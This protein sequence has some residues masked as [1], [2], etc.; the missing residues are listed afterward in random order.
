MD[1]IP[2]KLLSPVGDFHYFEDNQ[3]LTAAQLNRFLDYFD[4]QHRLT[5]A[6]GL[7]SGILC[8]LNV[9]L[10]TGG[11][12]IVSAGAGITTDGDIIHVDADKTLAHFRSFDD[13]KAQYAPFKSGATT[14]PLF[15]L[16]TDPADGSS[17]LADFGTVTSLILNDMCLVLYLNSYLH[18]PENCT[19]TSCEITGTTQVAEL[20]F[21]LVRKNDLSALHGSQADPTA[22]LADVAIERVDLFQA[23]V[24]G[25]NNLMSRF[26]ASINRSGPALQNA[27]VAAADT[28]RQKI[29]IQ[30]GVATLWRNRL[31]AIFN[32]NE[33]TP[34]LPYIHD[35]ARDL[36]DAYTEYRDALFDLRIECPGDPTLYPKHLM[37][38]ELASSNPALPAE[39]RHYFVET[40]A[41][42]RNSQA[43]E[44]A[45]MLFERLDRMVNTFD[46]PTQ[47]NLPVRV[48][49][50]RVEN[51]PLGER[52]IPFYYRHDPARPL[53]AV[54]NFEK[55]SRQRTHTI[56]GY[57]SNEYGADTPTQNAARFT[58]GKYDFFRIEGFIGKDHKTA[59]DTITLLRDQL[60]LPFKI[61]SIQIEQSV[62]RPIKDIGRPMVAPDLNIL[63]HHYRD[64]L[65]MNLEML[66]KYKVE[67]VAEIEKAM[68][69][70]QAAEL[71]PIRT[72]LAEAKTKAAEFPAKREQVSNMLYQPL[73]AF[74]ES[75]RFTGFRKAYNE[76]AD[77]AREFTVKTHEVNQSPVISPAHHLIFDN[78][79]QKFDRLK[80]LFLDREESI[81]RKYLF[82]SFFNTHPGLEH[83]AGVTE[84]GTFVLVYTVDAQGKTRV[85]ADFCLPYCC[86]IDTT[87]DLPSVKPLLPIRPDITI[88]P[89]LAR[90]DHL[91]LFKPLQANRLGGMQ[92]EF[93]KKQ[94]DIEKAI[95][96]KQKLFEKDIINK[97]EV[98]EA[99]HIGKQT[100]FEEKLQGK[101][102]IFEK[103]VDVKF[104]TKLTDNIW[105]VVTKNGGIR[106]TNIALGADI[107][108]AGMSN[109]VGLA[110]KQAE[111]IKELEANPSRTPG[112][113][114][115][116]DELKI[117]HAANLATLLDNVA[118]TT[119]DITLD[120]DQAKVLEAVGMM[121]EAQPNLV[122]NNTALDTAIK[123]SEIKLADKPVANG[124][125][126]LKI[127]K[128]K[129]NK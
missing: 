53:V 8:G 64:E 103:E 43:L 18:T 32:V 125:A 58:T 57:R 28:L 123:N 74:A 45:R 35:F 14:I 68:P 70:F 65:H 48:T 84:G 38:A 117:S 100:T 113:D 104:S 114:K 12:I 110:G 6:K 47:A 129:V 55:S 98:F 3:V 77:M 95:E 71:A 101:Q 67:T 75:S 105:N 44:R 56:P 13:S 37:A 126:K 116:L 49:P 81:L 127:S 34:A 118:S 108:D 92:A 124:F 46:A 82:D 61:E 21:L 128:F 42:V 120:S 97:Q 36:A 88:L 19:D 73:A 33:S 23:Q 85:V 59:H 80:D 66:G 24:T 79:T 20:L 40:P 5:R 112:E 22:Q 115:F 107:Q 30:D 17:P 60:N 31:S 87:V 10:V 122:K 83:R 90:L 9:R 11:Q 27:M 96:G 50:S 121:L 89:P 62:L 78:T 54:W 4:R 102:S 15:Q 119:G 69:R 109:L 25:I 91:D 76:S 52:A 63:F 106:D 29:G 26:A 111:S 1:N 86:V 7:G 72:D 94:D 16:S 2:V 93:L 39:F 51:C 41:P 99:T